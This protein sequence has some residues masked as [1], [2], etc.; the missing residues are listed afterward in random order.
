VGR[1]QD[2]RGTAEAGLFPR[3]TN[4][5][6]ISA[7]IWF[8]AVIP[9]RG[10]SSFSRI[11]ARYRGL[12]FLHRADGDIPNAVLLFRH[13]APATQ[14][15]AFQRNATSQRRVDH[16]AIAG[17]IPGTL[18]LS[19]RP[20]RSEPKVQCGGTKLPRS[21]RSGA[22]MHQRACALA[23]MALRSDGSEVAGGRFWT[24]SLR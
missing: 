6:P 24:V 11:T 15:S 17:G 13:R 14:D 18:P 7:V 19:L 23:E 5:G 10:A 2:S 3:G 20:L 21:S 8:G 9:A 16:P 12:R 4:G 1:S 22:E